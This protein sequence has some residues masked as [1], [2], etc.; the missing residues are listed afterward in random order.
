MRQFL[1]IAFINL[2]YRA[3]VAADLAAIPPNSWVP[4]QPRIIQ[5]KAAGEQGQWINAG[6]N[7]LVYDPDG[8]R[9]LFYDRWN[10]KKH[11]GTTIYGNCL[12]AFDAAAD[13]LT[14][15]KIDNWTKLETP[16]GGYRTPPLP[17]NDREPTPCPRHVYHAFDYVPDTRSVFISNGAN[18]T[19]LRDGKLLGH[20]LCTD[21]WRFD[22]EKKSWTRIVSKDQPPNRLEDGMAYCPDTKAIVY[23]GHGKIWILDIAGGEWRKSRTELPRFHMGMTVFYDAPRKRMLLAGG[24]LY[25]KWQTTAGGFNTLYAFDPK[26]EEITRLADCPTAL[27]RG[28][29]SHDTHCDLFIVAV[30]LSGKGVEQPSGIFA[31]DPKIDA[32][33]AIK[34][35]N[36]VPYENGWMP[37]CYDARHDCHIGM[38]KTTFYVF[39]H[40]PINE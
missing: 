1:L 15:L 12:Y 24:G 3:C 13:T 20:D 17:E 40:V 37:L 18:Q 32:W 8:K 6:W 4:I 27:C 23:A 31:Y 28:A 26:S 34:P 7:K 36:P 16:D 2:V 39:R 35:A 9:V 25:D 22:L 38:A 5:P 14:P 19:A 11:G 33:H 29:L 21:T 10:D 30:A